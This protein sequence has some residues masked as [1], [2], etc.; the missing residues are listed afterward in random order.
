MLPYKTEYDAIS[1]KDLIMNY[2]E[3]HSY[4][5]SKFNLLQHESHLNIQFK[6]KKGKGYSKE[7]VNISQS[8]DIKA[9]IT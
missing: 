9:Y 5:K 7:T 4:L 6:I 1:Y 2:Y 3:L 8:D